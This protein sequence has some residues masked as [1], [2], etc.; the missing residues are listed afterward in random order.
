MRIAEL[1]ERITLDIGA[2]RRQALAALAGA[3]LGAWQA[4]ALGSKKTRKA[5]KRAKK[6]G[7]KKC[8]NQEGECVQAFTDIC[9][10]RFE[11]RA[12][13]C[14]ADFTPC[15]AVLVDCQVASFFEC[16]L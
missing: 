9:T 1:R 2:S 11:D 12:P 7:K 10:A 3:G 16:V 15:C 6:K 4:P 8:R 14:I 13:A 5:V